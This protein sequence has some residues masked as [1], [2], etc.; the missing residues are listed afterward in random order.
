MPGSLF[1][2]PTAPATNWLTEG[3][4]VPTGTTLISIIA[5]ADLPD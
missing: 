3:D 4:A 1:N 2:I 5:I